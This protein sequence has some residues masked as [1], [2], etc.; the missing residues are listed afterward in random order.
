[1]NEIQNNVLEGELKYKGTIIV[2]YKIEYPV[3]VSSTY[4]YGQESFNKYNKN[5]AYQLESYCKGELFEQA[6]QVYKYNT[7]HGYPI[8]QFQLVLE[9]KITFNEERVISL[10][11]DQYTFTGGAHGSTIRSAQT[12]D[13]LLG[14]KML[15]REFYP[16]D[17]AYVVKILREITAQIQ[18]QIETG[19]GVYFDN[20]CQL[21]INTFQLQNFYILPEKTV[22][23][24][25][26]YAIA[27]YSSGIPT[28]VLNR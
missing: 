9:S 17:S 13:L 8:M 20:Y 27:P 2:T 5:K 11:Q 10:Y 6:K 19:T 26:Q 1:M 15:L 4:K 16:D 21:V 25:Q 24:F 3:I 12:W 23:F 28:F 7:E 22:I 14:R 18:E